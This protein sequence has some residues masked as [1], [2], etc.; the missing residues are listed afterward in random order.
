MAHGHPIIGSAIPISPTIQAL[1]I[2]RFDTGHAIN[3]VHKPYCRRIPVYLVV[4]RNDGWICRSCETPIR[5][6]MIVGRNLLESGLYCLNCVELSGRIQAA[7]L[8]ALELTIKLKRKSRRHPQGLSAMYFVG[9][10]AQLERYKKDLE[11]AGYPIINQKEV[12]KKP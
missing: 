11:G 3:G 8:L 6:G 12:K 9:T 1:T 5:H 2:K 10:A 4:Y 7:D